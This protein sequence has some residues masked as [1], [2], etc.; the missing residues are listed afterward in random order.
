MWLPSTLFSSVYMSAILFLFF[1][2]HIN[3]TCTRAVA[4]QTIPEVLIWKNNVTW[5]LFYRRET[6]SGGNHSWAD[7]CE[8]VRIVVTFLFFPSGT[9]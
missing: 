6:Q 4:H 1:L 2:R 3:C 7:E 5:L 8:I 9:C